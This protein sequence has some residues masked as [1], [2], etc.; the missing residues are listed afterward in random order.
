[1]R[2]QEQAAEE[3]YEAYRELWNAE[4]EHYDEIADKRNS[5]LEELQE[6]Q[7]QQAEDAAALIVDTGAGM[8]ENMHDLDDYVEDMIK[9][10]AI[11]LLKAFALQT[12]T[13]AFTGGLGGKLLGASGGGKFLK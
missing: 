7:A 3:E 13:D 2:I 10:W 5:Q 1:V 12:L 11:Q 6:I 9:R 8:L 4:A